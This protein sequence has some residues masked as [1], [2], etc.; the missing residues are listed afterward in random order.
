MK[1]DRCTKTFVEPE[2]PLQLVMMVVVSLLGLMQWLSRQREGPD[3]YPDESSLGDS[4]QELYV[5]EFLDY[6]ESS[7]EPLGLPQPSW[8]HFVHQDVPHE[9][10][11]VVGGEEEGVAVSLW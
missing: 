1:I 2:R 6:R 5:G 3:S 4:G 10:R 11:T 7:R 8:W 9:L